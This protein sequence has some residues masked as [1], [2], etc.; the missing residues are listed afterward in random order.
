MSEAPPQ[1]LMTE[2]CFATAPTLDAE[3]ILAAIR[4]VRPDADLV[5]DE[6]GGGAVVIAYRELRNIY[7]DT[8]SAMLLNAITAPVAESPDHV[9]DLRYTRDWAQAARALGESRYAVL[10]ADLLGRD[11]PPTVRMEAYQAAL[12]AVVEAAAPL[13]TWWPGSQQA[14]RPDQAVA[15][16]L[17]ALVNVRL[18]TEPGGEEGEEI[19]VMDTLGLYAF[20]LPDLQCRFRYLDRGLMANLLRNAADFLFRG[21]K[22]GLDRPMRG[23]TEEQRWPVLPAST[24]I[25]PERPTLTLDP[26]EPFTAAPA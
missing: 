24:I 5:P 9:R 4:R 20:G 1:T 3:Q 22:F 11:V 8:R 25:G 7:P 23:F 2:L 12:A 21:G 16:P 13:A 14:V 19:A 6:Q 15:D 10:V 18:H 26:G 17:R